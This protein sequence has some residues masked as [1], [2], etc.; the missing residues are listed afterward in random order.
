VIVPSPSLVEEKRGHDLLYA[1]PRSAVRAPG[2]G[3][4][5]GPG[6]LQ[7]LKKSGAGMLL[8]FIAV[9]GAIFLFGLAGTV[10]P[11]RDGL[12]ENGDPRFFLAAMAFGTVFLLM[13][14]RMLQV[15]MSGAAAKLRRR[16]RTS[17]PW[18]S[19]YPWRPEG[20]EPDY[21]KAGGSILGPVAFFSLIALFNI[22]WASGSLILMAI[23]VVFDLFALL[24]LVDI[25]RRIWQ[26]VRHRRPR[27]R[28]TTFP[29]FLGE[30]LEGVVQLARPLAARG[31][32]T[33]TL[34]LVR[35]E[36]RS[37]GQQANMVEEA[38]V[39]YTQTR[40]VGASGPLRTLELAFDV[41]TDLPGT[42]FFAVLPTYWQVLIEV[43]VAGP[44][45]ESVFLAPVYAR[46]G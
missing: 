44:D 26:A 1:P 18:R 46:A 2:A 39:L 31:P 40:A 42:D 23:L 6:F 33:A 24:I 21:T 17:E 25:V 11:Y 28:W 45:F 4:L 14:S 37:G 13:A 7:R 15:A 9:G 12:R 22:G 34:R 27:I 35:D 19:D 5:L 16:P 36:Q 29:A 10:G 38:Y 32:A 30:R 43:P 3:G 41:P 8:L 20:M